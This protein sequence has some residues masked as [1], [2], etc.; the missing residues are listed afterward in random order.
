M[1]GKIIDWVED[2][3]RFN[4]M[5]LEGAA[6]GTEIAVKPANLL[7]IEVVRAA[8]RRSSKVALAVGS[9]K[10]PSKTY[11]VVVACRTRVSHL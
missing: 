3:G 6:A 8:G 11:R 1:Q 10:M 2:R 7:E 9:R 4:V 5:V